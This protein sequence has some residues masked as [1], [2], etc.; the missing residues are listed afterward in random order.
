VV[1]VSHNVDL[2]PRSL[3]RGLRARSR[4]GRDGR[5]F[6]A[7]RHAERSAAELLRVLWCS[8][9]SPHR[10]EI[11]CA[12]TERRRAG[13][14]DRVD[15]I[16]RSGVQ[17]HRRLVESQG[18]VCA[19]LPRK[20]FA[21]TACAGPRVTRRNFRNLFPLPKGTRGTRYRHAFVIQCAEE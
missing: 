4:T 11:Q 9:I 12:G 18:R 14:G 21:E 17:A 15:M 8:L 3:R 7:T 2:Y 10:S 1:P 5:F 20:Q 16:R 6:T 13:I 19:I